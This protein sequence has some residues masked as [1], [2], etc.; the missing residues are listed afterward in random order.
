MRSAS[1][2]EW[3]IGRFTDRS[4]A[5]WIIGDLN[6]VQ[7]EKGRLWFWLSVA[8]ILIRLGWRPLTAFV[9]A[10]YAGN[11]ALVAFQRAAFAVPFDSPHRAW[12]IW[13]TVLENLPFIG[14]VLWTGLLYAAIRYGIRDR[15]V[16]FVLAMTG[17]VSVITYYWWEPFVPEV[18]VALIVA[19]A[20]ACMLSGKGR[21]N[22]LILVLFVSIGRVSTLFC[23]YLVHQHLIFS[24][25]MGDVELRAHSSILWMIFCLY[26]LNAWILTAVF[27]WL[28]HWIP[29]ALTPQQKGKRGGSLGMVI[30]LASLILVATVGMTGK[31]YILYPIQAIGTNVVEVEYSGGRPGST[32]AQH[33][34]RNDYLTREDEKAVLEQV[35]FVSYSSPMLQIHDR[36]GFGSGVVKDILVLGVSPQYRRMRNLVLT[37]GRFF[38]EEDDIS[39]SKSAVV[40]ETFARQK[41][42]TIN[43]VGRTFQ[44]TGIPFTVIGTFKEAVDTLGETEVAD[45]TILIPYSVARY[46]TGTDA[47]KSIFFSIRDTGDV[48]RA[49]KE[50]LKVINSRHQF[51][52]VYH[53]RT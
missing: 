17:L 11:W 44:I 30:G 10:F 27:S 8:G 51:G 20:A 21:R 40:T 49:A 52:S 2:A 48:E 35:P 19:I 1:I 43:A 16:H 7:S 39:H 28:R 5:A 34:R 37:A 24:G 23:G 6:E 4:R 42:G 41:F 32:S 22:A 47:I 46:F 36:I 12:G 45:Q 9:A 18:C 26:L 33:D 29:L 13:E 3:M 53:A 25:P 15:L 14:A 50:I 38:D 31:Q